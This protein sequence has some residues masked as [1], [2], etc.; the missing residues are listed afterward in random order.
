MGISPLAAFLRIGKRTPMAI[1]G[2]RSPFNLNGEVSASN[3]ARDTGQ[4]IPQC[5]LCGF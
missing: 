1:T 5:L 2:H 3:P 4:G